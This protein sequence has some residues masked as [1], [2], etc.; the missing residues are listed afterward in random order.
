MATIKRFEDIHSWQKARE[1][2]N[3]IGALIDGGR[4]KRN[5]KLIVQ[6]ERSAG[7]IMDN[8]A[9]DLSEVVIGNLYNFFMCRKDQQENSGRNY[10]GRLIDIISMKVNLMNYTIK[11]QKL[12]YSSKNL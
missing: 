3:K 9:E 4:F 1:L 6:I 10:I 5:Y 11:L 2:N 8:I 7:S 12:L